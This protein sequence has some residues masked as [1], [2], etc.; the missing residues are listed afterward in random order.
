MSLSA[1]AHGELE[2][3]KIISN[4]AYEIFQ[5]HFSPDRR[6]LV[7]EATR[8]M[9]TALESSLYVAAADG[10]PWIR[11]TDGKQWDDKP[12]WSPDGKSIY[13]LSRRGGFFN[14]WGIRFDPV[15]GKPVGQ[16]FKITALDRASLMVPQDIQPVA[17]S[18]SQKSLVLTASEVSG[19]IWTLDNAD[20]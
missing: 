19:S 5:P 4:P 16:P 12:C 8:S 18:I 1:A 7:F 2:P 17:L 6:W 11:I 15:H 9:P 14:V 10:G 13:F 20:K 3:R